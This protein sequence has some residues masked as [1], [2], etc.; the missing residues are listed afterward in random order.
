MWVGRRFADLPG[1]ACWST[2]RQRNCLPHLRAA[3]EVA[4]DE[5]INLFT[6]AQALLGCSF[7]LS[8]TTDSAQPWRLSHA[9][10]ASLDQT[11]T[12]PILR[13]PPAPPQPSSRT[14]PAL[15]PLRSWLLGTGGVQST[16]HMDRS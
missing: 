12:P 6:Y 10:V 4:A 16:G 15:A 5:L 14:P 3:A 9:E 2:S 8:R 13:P 11:V 7:I 1:S